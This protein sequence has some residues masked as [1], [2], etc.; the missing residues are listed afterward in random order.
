M[1]KM[2]LI[3]GP[4]VVESEK[5]TMLV[6]EHLVKVCENL[7]IELIF[8]ASYQKANRTRRDSFTG[9]QRSEAL[10][11]IQR[12]GVTFKIPTLTD[13]HETYDADTAAMYVDVLQIPAFLCRQTELLY[14]AARTGLPINIKKGQFASVTTMQHAIDK[15]LEYN[16]ECTIYVTERGTTFGYDD[17][18]IDMRNVMVIS[19]S[20]AKCIVDIT[21]SLGTYSGYPA[22]IETMGRCAIAAGAHG[23]F[24]ETHPDILNALSDSKSMLPLFMVEK[25]LNNILKIWTATEQ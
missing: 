21:H 20:Y 4:C 7:P 13:I 1:N 3:A 16:K 6:A 9:I 12:V 23:I 8:K 10:R 17:L 14:A 15:V 19:H 24:L 5:I 22:M 25:T 11:I 18:V 2:I